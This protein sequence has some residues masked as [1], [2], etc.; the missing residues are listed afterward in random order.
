MTPTTER[1]RAKAAARGKTKGSLK[2]EVYRQARL[3]HGWLS[4]LAFLALIFFS[5][6]GL[7]L[8][9]PEW[10][11][12]ESAAKPV[13]T[14]LTLP[15]GDLARARAAADPGRAIAEMVGHGT[16]L[17][18]AYQSGEVI[19]GEAQLRTE[20]VN[21][22]SDILVD[23]QTG[24]AEVS[25]ERAPLVTT[26]NDLHRGKNAGAVWKLIIDASAI[27]VLALSLI[28]Y[29]LFFSLRFRLRTGLILT[30][31]SLAALLAVFFLLVP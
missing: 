5:A 25:T 10:V 16:K 9:H 23:M 3:W 19:D 30:G 29:V 1:R 31:I 17:L 7:L 11:K 22:A 6:T 2:G 24:K 13:E 14:S 26:L 28:G 18:G 12:T 15:A 4:A 20:G 27:L 21:G 8:N